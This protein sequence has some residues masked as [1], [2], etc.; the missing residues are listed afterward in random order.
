MNHQK[1]NF[2]KKQIVAWIFLLAVSLS[3]WFYGP[4]IHFGHSAPLQWVDKRLYLISICFLLWL[5][6]FIA[7]DIQTAPPE[8]TAEA[9]VTAPTEDIEKHKV[10]LKGQ[11]QGALNFLKKTFIHK[12][13]NKIYLDQLPWYLL[14]GPP[15]SGKTS[16]LTQSGINFILGK[17]KKSGSSHV[18]LELCDWWATRDLVLVDVPGHFTFQPLLWQY[19]LELI[20][21]TRQSQTIEG[22]V[23]ALNLPEL[24]KNA[25]QQKKEA[26][27]DLKKTIQDIKMASGR[28]MPLH[29]VITK[30]DLLPGFNEFFSELSNEE[31][32]QAW[33]TALPSVGQADTLQDIFSARFNHLIKRLN[34]QLLSRLHQERD[35]E[36]RSYIK[37]FPLYIEQLKEAL[38]QFIKDHVTDGLQLQSIHLTSARQQ[39]NDRPSL[40]SSQGTAQSLQLM[41]APPPE[42]RSYFVKQLILQ[43]ILT[44]SVAQTPV[45]S[46]VLRNFSYAM[47]I[48]IVV[49]AVVLLGR[50][51]KLSLKRT[52]A[53]Q[54]DLA[55]YQ[56]G[57]ISSKGLSDDLINCLP[58]LKA[59]REAA[60]PSADKLLLRFYSN[61]SQET[62]EAIYQQALQGIVLPK[63]KHYFEAYLQNAD[64]KNPEQVY[65]VLKAYL[66]LGD[67]SFFK[68]DD[69]VENLRPLLPS[70]I[71][72]ADLVQ[73][74]TYI[75]D[76]LSKHPQEVQLNKTL[77]TQARKQLLSLSNLNL[78]FVLLK[79]VRPNRQ[80]SLVSLGTHFGNPPVFTSRAIA[81]KIP[82]MFTAKEFKKITTEEINTAA[83]DVLNGN[84]A[85]GR[86]AVLAS[87][88][89]VDALAAQLQ[90]QYI[91]NY[92]DI[93]ESLLANL[94]LT[95]PNN[96]SQIAEMIAIITSN[97]SPLLQLLDTI[98][99]NTAFLPITTASP[100]LQNLS[101][102]LMDANHQQS[103][104]LYQI[105]VSLKQLD[106]Y[107]K[108][109]TQSSDS[110]TA[111]LAATAKRMLN[112]KEGPITQIHLIAEQSPEPMKTWLH[113]IAT[114]TWRHLL[115]ESGL[116]IEKI[117]EQTILPTY[118]AQIEGHY[119]FNQTAADEV[120]LQQFIQFFG[121]QGQLALFYQAYLKPFIIEDKNHLTWRIVD[122][123]KLP[124]SEDALQRLEHATH[125]Q[126]AFFPNGDNKLFVSFALQP[127]SIDKSMKGFL[128]NING[129]E[130]QYQK[131]SINNDRLI[132]WP[133]PNTQHASSVN[134]ISPDNALVSKMA[135]GEWGWFK[136]VNHAT[137][138][139]R[140]RQE[141]YLNFNVN[142]H[143]AK[144]ILLIQGR[145]NPFLPLN[146]QQFELP[147]SL[148]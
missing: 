7:F 36:A 103:S 132:A 31:L 118:K 48:S 81:T 72:P 106:Q 100:K 23:L 29:I 79:N 80:D 117:W 89:A 25:R 96:L 146:L 133:G 69:V 107:L 58:L 78:G 101:I 88:L 76:D 40:Y 37:D 34:N 41:S 139:L 127:V 59:L 46:T 57:L 128:F 74:T 54:Q 16:L 17:Q 140:S 104:L 95:T 42:A 75:H 83:N 39:L 5:L 9:A 15:S 147:E 22:A 148:G 63:I 50:D 91:A 87:P 18:A 14:I 12:H 47:A 33:G 112:D 60:H 13:G 65:A 137:Q 84:W 121:Q 19:F 43:Q 27:F 99:Q 116:Q 143:I 70:T 3:I 28:P 120:N 53:I 68:M 93:W 6:K 90:A 144:Y 86:H 124:F 49:T 131:N 66:M 61:K 94:E 64:N 35:R 129:Q 109:I 98:K 126:Q 136:L 108:N 71:D 119:P 67:P 45:P 44:T 114:Q 125:L 77:I 73:L 2:F 142:G 62:A 32:A 138:N 122:N 30:C 51:F 21:N 38:A 135:E 92:V 55:A 145:F 105:F 24:M 20:K 4:L 8:T 11:F 82:A 115:F 134:F 113:T 110:K 10:R 130:I 56:Q 141:L 111:L 1:V 123:A 85:L 97:H 102:L 52:E 26:G